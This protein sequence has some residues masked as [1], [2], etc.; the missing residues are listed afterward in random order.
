LPLQAE[1]AYRLRIIETLP[2]SGFRLKESRSRTTKRSTAGRM[3][4]PQRHPQASP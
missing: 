2:P 1:F 4:L 3:V